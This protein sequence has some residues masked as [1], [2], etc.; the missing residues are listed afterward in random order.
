MTLVNSLRGRQRYTLTENM[1]LAYNTTGSP[2]LDLFGSCGGMRHTPE[3][4][5]RLMF[6]KAL[7]EDRQLAAR[8]AFRCRDARDGAGERRTGRIML[9]I[10]AQRETDSMRELLPLIPEYGRWDDLLVLLGTPLH[11]DVLKLIERQ[12]KEDIENMQ[13]EKPVSLL[14]K[15]LPSIN[16]SSRKTREDARIILSYLKMSE[17]EYRHTLSSLRS[18]LNITEKNLSEKEYGRI[19][20][21]EVPSCAMHRYRNAF[22]SHDEERFDAFLD[23]VSK[24][25]E[26]INSSVL[27]PYDITEKYLYSLKRPDSV[28]EEQWKALPDYVSDGRDILVMA[29]VSGSMHGRPMATSV[30]LATVRSATVS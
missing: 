20:Y 21:P 13:K 2:L 15:W 5:I 29:D 25:E 28:L 12:L 4:N 7:N 26:K 30:G 19:V 11:E 23:S 9:E 14:A 27:Y 24:G 22:R 6:H 3:E 17:K 18:Y 8:L 16:A 10:L 1:A